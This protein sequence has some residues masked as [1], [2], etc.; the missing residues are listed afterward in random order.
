ME[1]NSFLIM[2]ANTDCDHSYL[3][4][5]R[6]GPTGRKFFMIL[7]DE[8]YSCKEFFP[9]R[10]DKLSESMAKWIERWNRRVRSCDDKTSP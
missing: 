5:K 3:M 9:V 2:P 8:C 10:P 1:G 7:V 4:R 6:V